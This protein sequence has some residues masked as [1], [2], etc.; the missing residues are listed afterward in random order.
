[1]VIYLLTVCG[2][3][4]QVAKKGVGNTTYPLAETPN[5]KHGAGSVQPKTCRLLGPLLSR[6][7]SLFSMP[8]P[9]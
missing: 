2:F 6:S 1:M 7:L 5:K 3:T 4:P 8:G 9:K